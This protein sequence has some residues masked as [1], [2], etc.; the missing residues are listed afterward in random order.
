M[1]TLTAA[2]DPCWAGVGGLRSKCLDLEQKGCRN[3]YVRL[4]GSVSVHGLAYR[5]SGS[6]NFNYFG[7]ASPPR[8]PALRIFFTVASEYEF[9]RC[10]QNDD[11]VGVQT[12]LLHHEL[13]K[14]RSEYLDVQTCLL[15]H[16]LY[17]WRL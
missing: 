14:C 17:N 7:W 8:K 3:P 10:E 12:S 11:S 9:L 1:T 13:H 5:L 15:Q 6:E 16:Q 2:P 4:S